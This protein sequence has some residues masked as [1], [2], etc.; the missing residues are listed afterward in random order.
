MIHSG[1]R[2][3]VT[4]AELV[5][6]FGR[7]QDHAATNPLFVTHH[8]RD[9]FVM[10]SAANYRALVDGAGADERSGDDDGLETLTDLITQGFVM[11]DGDLVIDAINPAA[12]NY[13]RGT[14]QRLVGKRL[15]DVC[16]GV[17]QSLVET[18]LIRALRSG[19]AGSFEAPSFS[20]P[21]EWFHIQTFPFGAGV[22]MLIRSIGHEMEARRQGAL[23][24]AS[25]AA[26]EAHGGIGYAT[27]SPRGTFADVDTR[28]A[29]MAGF[30]PSALRWM[31]PGDILPLQ[32]RV[33][34]KEQVEAVLAGSEPRAFDSELLVNRGGELPVRIS[35]AGVRSD[36]ANDGAIMI[37]TPR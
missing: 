34:A 4:S 9:R 36:R 16:P 7:W 5:R 29:G 33:E 27:L 31:R 20:T 11:F 19:E 3:S 30:A 37:V 14:R 1:Q 17:T 23:T 22:A 18:H 6:R 32:R 8:G 28:L 25:L 13:L 35:L 24:S 26:A 2:V 10:L 21:E 15:E 12:V